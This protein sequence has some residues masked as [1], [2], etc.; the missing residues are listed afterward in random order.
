MSSHVLA[1]VLGWH[2][3]TA[4][5]LPAWQCQA[6]HQS[7]PAL[8]MLCQ[9]AAQAPRAPHASS[10]EFMAHGSSWKRAKISSQHWHCPGMGTAAQRGE[11]SWGRGCRKKLISHL[12]ISPLTPLPLLPAFP[13]AFQQFQGLQQIQGQLSSI[14]RGV[15]PGGECEFPAPAS[16]D[17]SCSPGYSPLQGW[18]PKT[19][20]LTSVSQSSPRCQHRWNL[21]SHS[22]V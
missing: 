7:I 9:A 18:L 1:H 19:P 6:P 21:G 20:G 17:P 11:R 4:G 3:G 8:G 12:S 15:Q 2:H 5:L 16:L 22:P 13:T 14:K 10:G